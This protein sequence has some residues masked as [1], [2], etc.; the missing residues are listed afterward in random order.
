MARK[1]KICDSTNKKKIEKEILKGTA[2]SWIA[3]EYGVSFGVVKR[4]KEEHMSLE[5]AQSMI[6]RI[7]ELRVPK[8]DHVKELPQLSNLSDCISYIHTEILDIYLKISKT[9]LLIKT[10]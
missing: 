6:T 7:P 8:I 3:K 10:I 4:H 2:I 1:C 5:I 9:Y